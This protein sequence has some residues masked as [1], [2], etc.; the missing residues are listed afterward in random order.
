VRI[1]PGIVFTVL[2][3]PH[4]KAKSFIRTRNHLLSIAGQGSMKPYFIADAL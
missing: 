1:V 2:L 3:C 4:H